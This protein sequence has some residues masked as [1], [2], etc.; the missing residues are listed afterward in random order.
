[1]E[2]ETALKLRVGSVVRAR[3]SFIS[4]GTF[5]EGKKYVLVAGAKPGFPVSVEFEGQKPR[6]MITNC[7]FPLVDD[8]GRRVDECYLSFDLVSAC[9]F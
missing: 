2:F 8:I 4:S 1:M 6:K 7:Y 9:I 3:S 5:T